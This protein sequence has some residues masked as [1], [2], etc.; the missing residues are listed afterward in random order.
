MNKLP[1]IHFILPGGGVRGAFQAGF[2]YKLR[3]IYGDKFEIARIDG[4]I[5]KNIYKYK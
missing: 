2:L 1:K 3:K 5:E 4:T